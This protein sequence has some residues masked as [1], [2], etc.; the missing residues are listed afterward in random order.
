[1][2]KATGPVV[3]APTEHRPA[4]AADAGMRADGRRGSAMIPGL[5]RLGTALSAD[6]WL[7]DLDAEPPAETLALLSSDERERAGRFV[8]EHDRRRWAAARRALRRVLALRTGS[9]AASLRF[10]AGEFGKPRL[11]DHPDCAFSHSHSGSWVLIGVARADASGVEI[12]VDIEV[13]QP[14]AG[15][16]DLLAQCFTP[17]EGRG[18]RAVEGAEHSRRL[19]AGW[20][21]KEACLKALGVGL[22]I[23]P[24]SFAAGTVEDS[25]GKTVAIDTPSGM[26]TVAVVSLALPGALVGALA[27]VPRHP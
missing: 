26:R 8:F 2:S 14:V 15:I 19:L 21:R 18:L 16:D 5:R 23:E 27:S 4:A 7:G 17:D 20:T 9:D 3:P 25:A 1:M 13:D 6:F 24:A 12:G 22:R 11:L 10:G